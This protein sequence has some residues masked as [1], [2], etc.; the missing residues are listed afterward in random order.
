MMK[1]DKSDKEIH[2]GMWFDVDFSKQYFFKNIETSFVGLGDAFKKITTEKL[3]GRIGV[4]VEITKSIKVEYFD[5]TW[6]S[7][8]ALIGTEWLEKFSKWIRKEMGS[9]DD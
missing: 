4:F 7:A 5:N 6:R 1:I 9:I 3:N 8:P 2:N